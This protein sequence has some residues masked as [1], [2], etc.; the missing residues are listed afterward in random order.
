MLMSSEINIADIQVPQVSRDVIE[1]KDLKHYKYGDNV[2]CFGNLKLLISNSESIKIPGKIK[3]DT[4]IIITGQLSDSQLRTSLTNSPVNPDYNLSIYDHTGNTINRY[5]KNRKSNECGSVSH[6]LPN[7]KLFSQIQLPEIK[8]DDDIY[9]NI[10]DYE[11]IM[12]LHLDESIEELVKLDFEKFKTLTTVNLKRI[13]IYIKSNIYNTISKYINLEETFGKINI[14][15]NTSLTL[16]EYL[17]GTVINTS[18]DLFQGH[19]EFEQGCE[20]LS[21][22]ST[23][24]QCIKFICRSHGLIQINSTNSINEIKFLT[25]LKNTNQDFNN[26]RIKFKGKHIAESELL[27]QQKFNIDFSHLN[28]LND[29]Y[30]FFTNIH[31]LNDELLNKFL[32]DNSEVVIRFLI[33]KE[34]NN[35]EI[36]NSYEW[37]TI[38][39]ENDIQKSSKQTLLGIFQYS[40]SRRLFRNDV[41]NL[42]NP[43]LGRQFSVAHNF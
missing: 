36:K 39:Y 5:L 13:N 31:E 10:S 15:N 6:N 16:V 17:M 27:E 37:L 33:E 9:L 20:P 3:A 18:N 29:M 11:S 42:N 22:F 40:N 28:K 12:D 2:V 1:I 21:I 19:L 25:L 41:S 23:K 4:H 26:V 24:N 38:E 30:W 34:R 35:I 43:Q 7:L 32:V 14:T 8:D